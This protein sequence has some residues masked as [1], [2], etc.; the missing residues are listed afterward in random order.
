M[1]TERPATWV[2]VASAWAQA[3]NAG[4]REKVGEKRWVLLKITAK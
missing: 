1:R 3:R 2:S 4:T